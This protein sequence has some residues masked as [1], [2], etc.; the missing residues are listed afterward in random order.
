MNALAPVSTRID[1]VVFHLEGW[2]SVGVSP[3]P[4]RHASPVQLWRSCQS[5]PVPCTAEPSTFPIAAGNHCR[6][7]V[8]LKWCAFLCGPFSIVLL[9]CRAQLWSSWMSCLFTR[10]RLISSLL[11]ARCR[12]L[13]LAVRCSH[14][15]CHPSVYVPGFFKVVLNKN[16]NRKDIIY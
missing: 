12:G 14:T 16:N 10:C 5:A 15:F 7:A 2:R 3:S 8:L 9:V 6:C 1:L 11:T 4:R 13:S